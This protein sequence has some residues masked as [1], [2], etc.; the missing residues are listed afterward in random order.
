MPQNALVKRG[1]IDPET[2][3]VLRSA[4]RTTR[5]MKLYLQLCAYPNRLEIQS[6]DNINE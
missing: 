2:Q 6:L 1:V 4:V 5:V 3:S